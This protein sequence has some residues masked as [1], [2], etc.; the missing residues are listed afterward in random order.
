MFCDP[1][2]SL[3][4]V[5]LSFIKDLFVYI[6]AIFA[7]YIVHKSCTYIFLNILHTNEDIHT[8]CISLLMNQKKISIA[9]S[10]NL[11]LTAI[12]LIDGKKMDRKK[13][14]VHCWG[15]MS[16]SLTSTLFFNKNLKEIKINPKLQ[17]YLT[18]V[19]SLLLFLLCKDQEIAVRFLQYSFSPI[20]ASINNSVY[21]LYYCI[22]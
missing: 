21:Y 22:A 1:Y 11:I 18:S 13:I 12:F 14:F 2:F 8:L 6:L 20:H 15:I 16:P 10:Y 3:V 4:C 19:P 7:C 9:S 5:I 17:L